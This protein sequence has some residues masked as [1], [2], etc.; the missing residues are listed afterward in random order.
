MI[1][2]VGYV[3]IESWLITRHLVR[4]SAAAANDCHQARWDYRQESG[5][6]RRGSV[7]RSSRC[8]PASASTI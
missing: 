5:G 2:W 4:S 8:W 1:N 6:V 3:I 7:A